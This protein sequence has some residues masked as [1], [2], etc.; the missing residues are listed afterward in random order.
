[1]RNTT[2]YDTRQL[3]QQPG[4]SNSNNDSAPDFLGGQ[5]S[6]TAAE[7]PRDE[8]SGKDSG[9]VGDERSELRGPGNRNLESCLNPSPGGRTEETPQDCREQP[10]DLSRSHIQSGCPTPQQSSRDAADRREAESRPNRNPQ[11]VDSTI[12]Q[13]DGS[14]SEQEARDAGAEPHSAPRQ[15]SRQNGGN[16]RVTRGNSPTQE[17]GRHRERQKS[18]EPLRKTSVKIATLNMNG[19]GS[20]T[21]AAADNK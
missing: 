3:Q 6:V 13:I 2:T 19:F 10:Y 15:E 4:L 11:R 7:N 16:T 8:D 5:P 12:Q 1:M 9:R 21:P 17:N 14:P 20:L 18:D